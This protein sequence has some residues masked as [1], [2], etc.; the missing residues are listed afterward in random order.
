MDTP[1]TQNLTTA[2]TQPLLSALFTA[3]TSK[4]LTYKLMLHNAITAWLG[5]YTSSKYAII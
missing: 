4:P 1:G 2:Q 5:K 3:K